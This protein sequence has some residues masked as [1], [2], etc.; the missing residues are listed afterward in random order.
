MTWMLGRAIAKLEKIRLRMI[1]ISID[2][3]FGEDN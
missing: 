2:M 3:I 1:M